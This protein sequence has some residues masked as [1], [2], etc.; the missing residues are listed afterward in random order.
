MMELQIPNICF[1]GA[2]IGPEVSNISL[3][4]IY[5]LILLQNI[6]FTDF[7]VVFKNNFVQI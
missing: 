2:N 1:K 4:V 7:L 3:R 5:N 6:N